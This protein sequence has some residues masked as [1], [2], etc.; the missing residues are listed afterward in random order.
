MAI[1]SIGAESGV[2]DL[3]LDAKLA[4]TFESLVTLTGGDAVGRWERA[5]W[6]VTKCALAS[7]VQVLLQSERLRMADA[8]VL[9]ITPTE[10]LTN[11]RV[12]ATPSG[13]N[14]YRVGAEWREGNHNDLVFALALVGW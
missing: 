9:A 3:L 4:K 2:V 5:E 12:E 1:D 8:L 10:D 13:H 6:R 14:A 11:F 7:F